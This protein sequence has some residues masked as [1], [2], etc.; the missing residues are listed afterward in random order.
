MNKRGDIGLVLFA[1]LTVALVVFTLISFATVNRNS[2]AIGEG[3]SAISKTKNEYNSFKMALGI[4]IEESFVDTYMHFAENGDYISGKRVFTGKDGMLLDEYGFAELADSE[5]ISRDFSILFLSNFN[6][7]V[8]EA[9]GSTSK[10]VFTRM[11]K[12]FDFFD[13]D[14]S[15]LTFE[16]NFDSD[17]FSLKFSEISSEK[18]YNKIKVIYS[19]G[20]D[21]K[22]DF[23][24]FGLVG[25]NNLY[26][27]KEKCKNLA[28]PEMKNC[29]ETEL[30]NF[31][32]EI[33]EKEIKQGDEIINKP[34]VQLESKKSFLNR[35]KIKFSFFPV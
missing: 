20:L 18:E 30:E 10:G 13:G 5:K 7:R 11:P 27:V 26:E 3:A 34:F 12:V 21:Y 8:N 28:L 2:L 22:Y 31:S 32:V 29:F 16:T 9:K 33:T 15:D 1:V 4:L 6:K 24:K 19:S 23:E 35:G 25:F 17:Y 14:I